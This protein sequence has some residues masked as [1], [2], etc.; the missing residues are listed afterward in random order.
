MEIRPLTAEDVFGAMSLA[1][2]E[3]LSGTAQK[4]PPQLANDGKQGRGGVPGRE[5]GGGGGGG[6][7][8]DGGVF[9]DGRDTCSGIWDI[10][11]DGDD[12]LRTL[13]TLQRVGSPT[14]VQGSRLNTSDKRST[15]SSNNSN[16]NTYAGNRSR[17][18]GDRQNHDNKTSGGRINNNRTSPLA[19]KGSTALTG[20]GRAAGDM[21]G[22]QPPQGRPQVDTTTAPTRMGG[23]SHRRSA[24]GGWSAQANNSPEFDICDMS[25]G[26]RNGG[27]GSGRVDDWGGRFR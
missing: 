14:K 9:D 17:G 16:N 11:D 6:A 24:M 4:P 2:L 25:L 22:F 8:D 13:P 26:A 5:R 3:K 12:G 1:S 20:G 7:G 23:T 19:S 15:T 21:W 27:S 18:S 10:G